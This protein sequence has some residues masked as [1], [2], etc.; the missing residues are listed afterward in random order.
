[1]QKI[2]NGA[3]GDGAGSTFDRTG[4]LVRS[5]LFKYKKTNTGTCT[6]ELKDADTGAVV[7]SFSVA[8][9]NPTQA[10]SEIALPKRFYGEISSSSGTFALDAWVDGV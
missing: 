3:T 6:L 8:A 1:M 7:R 5:G 9:T 2:F 4:D 10:I